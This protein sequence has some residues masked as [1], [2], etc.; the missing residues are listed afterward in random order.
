MDQDQVT[1]ASSSS[2]RGMNGLSP[3]LSFFFGIVS[4]LAVFSTIGFIVL[5]QDNSTGS[6]GSVQGASD[7][8]NGEA[9]VVNN[10]PTV[11]QPTPSAPV[12]ASSL[13]LQKVENVRGT[14]NYTIVEFSDFECPFCKRFHTTMQ[15]VF[16]EFDGKVAWAYEHF[17]IESLHSKAK[18]EA[19]ASECAAEQG[20]FW[21]YSD[22]IFQKTPSNNGLPEEELFKTADEVG[23]NRSKFESCLSSGKTAGKVEEDL[24]LSATMGGQG[25]PYSVIVDEK[26]KVVD[27][28]SGALPAEQIKAALNAALEN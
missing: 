27:T 18:R 7:E 24:A 1:Q 14:G 9:V 8:A 28:I 4:A 2:G 17:P 11:A 20:K 19:Q 12:G 22:L 10:N 26:G 6:S 25:T 21:E 15:E 5:L 13:D 16:K 23:L 3:K